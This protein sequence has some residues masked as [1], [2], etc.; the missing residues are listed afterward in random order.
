MRFVASISMLTSLLF[1]GCADPDPSPVTAVTD[2]AGTD[3]PVHATP[4]APES[5]KVIAPTAMI[6]GKSYAEQVAAWWQWALAIPKD[7]NPVAGKACNE[8]QKG[9]VFFL[10]GTDD[11]KPASR[12]CEVP[13]GKI[14]FFPLVNAVC[15]P[16]HEEE[17]CGTTK[18]AAELTECAKLP[19]PKSL[20]AT[21]DGVPIEGLDKYEVTSAQFS[22]KAPK[23]DAL[24]GCSGEIEENT[25]GIPKGDRFGVSDGYWI[26]LEPLPK[27][28]HHITFKA[29]LP[30]TPGS[31]GK[32]GPESFFVQDVSYEITVK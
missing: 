24:F 10:A 31:S 11:G 9:N 2:D 21:V 13:E 30:G 18:T 23:T 25:C 19:A 27:G 15:Y 6:D 8:G 20:K 5:A 16:C 1:V 14:L 29:V 4:I 12:S 17:G 32:P 3:A 28:T 7:K 22:W 26:A